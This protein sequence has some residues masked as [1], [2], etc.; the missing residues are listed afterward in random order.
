VL[1][2]VAIDKKIARANAIIAATSLDTRARRCDRAGGEL[3]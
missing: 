3:R 1:D 2:N